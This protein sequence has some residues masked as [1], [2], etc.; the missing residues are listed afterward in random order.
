[1]ALGGFKFLLVVTCEQTN[2]VFAIPLIERTA[3]HVAEALIS[4]VFCISGPPRFLS[5]DKDHV[6]TGKVIKTL[7]QSIECEMQVISPWNHRSSKAERQIQTIGNMICKRL[8]GKGEKWPLF[9]AL[10]SYSMNTFA[11]DALQGFTPFELVFIRKPRLLVNYN[12]KQ[13]EQYPIAVRPYIKLLQERAE[14][15]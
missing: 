14:F 13:I 7:L 11:S 6:L 5:V 12:F 15:I 2:F 9:A 10:G 1:M 8:E 3:T 4:R